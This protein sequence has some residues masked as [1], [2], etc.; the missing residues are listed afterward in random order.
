M[1]HGAALRVSAKK[2]LKRVNLGSESLEVI[3]RAL[4]LQT[5]QRYKLKLHKKSYDTSSLVHM[6]LLAVVIYKSSFSLNLYINKMNSLNIIMRVIH[7]KK[8]KICTGH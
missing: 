2:Y 6:C 1:S 3:G 8:W 5:P 7:I 4:Q